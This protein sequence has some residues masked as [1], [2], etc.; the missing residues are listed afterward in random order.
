MAEGGV[1]SRRIPETFSPFDFRI[2]VGGRIGV[3]NRH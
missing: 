2:E 1:G 3:V